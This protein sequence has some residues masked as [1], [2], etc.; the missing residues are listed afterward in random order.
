M[1]RISRPCGIDLWISYDY[2]C[3][4]KTTY[5]P[6][7]VLHICPGAAPAIPQW[8]DSQWSFQASCGHTAAMHPTDS[9][10]V[11]CVLWC[12]GCFEVRLAL[13]IWVSTISHYISNLYVIICLYVSFIMPIHSRQLRYAY[14]VVLDHT[15]SHHVGNNVR[16]RQPVWSGQHVE[17]S[18]LTT[19]ALSV[20]GNWWICI[21]DWPVVNFEK[22]NVYLLNCFWL[23]WMFLVPFL[24]RP[25]LEEWWLLDLLAT[26]IKSHVWNR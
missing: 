8:W 15:L 7:Q 18:S 23:E 21:Q 12:V 20:R 16:M 17:Q 4:G 14:S 10:W 26:Y 3:F 25:R 2:W 11:S 22:L 6:D 13:H 5:F 19:K 9:I 1:K 24:F